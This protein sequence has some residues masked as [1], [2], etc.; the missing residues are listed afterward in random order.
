M[1]YSGCVY[2]LR[3]KANGKVYIGQTT[4][5]KRRLYYH[6]NEHTGKFNNNPIYEAITEYGRDGF[7]V[8]VLVELE[9]ETKKAL[10]QKLVAVEKEKILEYNSI[11]SGFNVAFGHE[12]TKAVMEASIRAHKGMHHTEETK[13]KIAEAMRGRKMPPKSPE[14]LRRMSEAQ[15]GKKR[16]KES[17]EKQRASVT[18]EKNPFYGKE[19]SEESRKKISASR[20]GKGTGPDNFASRAVRCIETGEIFITAVEA[21]AMKGISSHRNISFACRGRTHTCGGYHWEYA[22]EAADNG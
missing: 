5:L 18:G 16:S 1:Q 19:H 9:A 7:D 15:K 4:N 11:E 8:E 14:T 17:I 6:F 10:F 12:P 13:R 20:K 2:L 21:A 22:D 3:C